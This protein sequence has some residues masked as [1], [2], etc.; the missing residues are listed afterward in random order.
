MR[1]A[2]RPGTGDGGVGGDQP[3][4]PFI[5]RGGADGVDVTILEVG[6]D[7]D[8]ERAYD[9]GLCHAVAAG[10]DGAPQIVACLQVSKP[11]RVRRGDIQRD[12]VGI[13]RKPRHRGA[14]IIRRH[15]A[16]LVGADIDPDDAGLPG[17][18]AAA[19][20]KPGGGRLHAAAVE[21]IAVDDGP[22]LRQPEDPRAR[23]AGLRKRGDGAKLDMT[24]PEPERPVRTGGVLVE[25]GGEAERI[26]EGKPGNIYR[27]IIKFGRRPDAAA[28]GLDSGPVRSLGRQQP[29]QARR[30]APDQ[31]ASPP[32]AEPAASSPASAARISATDRARP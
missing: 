13:G 17:R 9:T 25:T 5:Q 26:A 19:R 16:G 32:P 18:A 24:E 7:L 30:G 8:E 23:I 15:V 12:V 21:T 14:V 1:R 10:G 11:R 20:G 2:Q 22:V 31:A 28:Q 4:D 29:C 3:V 27:H 6:G